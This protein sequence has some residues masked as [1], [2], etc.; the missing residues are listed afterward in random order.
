MRS[1]LGFG[2]VLSAIS[3]ACYAQ[4][5][6]QHIDSLGFLSIG[7]D[8]GAAASA[9]GSNLLSKVSPGNTDY[10]VLKFADTQH[11]TAQDASEQYPNARLT[12]SGALEAVATKDL[13]HATPDSERVSKARFSALFDAFKFMNFY[14]DSSIS[15][16]NDVALDS[17][18]VTIGNL[19]FTPVYFTAGRY[20]VPFASFAGDTISAVGPVPVMLASVHADALSLGYNPNKPNSVVANTFVYNPNVDVNKSSAPGYGVNLALKHKFAELQTKLG[21]GYVSNIADSGGIKKLYS[22]S[23]ISHAVPAGDIN[24]SVSYGNYGVVAEYISALSDFASKDMTYNNRAALPSVLH[25][26]VYYNGRVL[27]KINTVSVG[28]TQTFQALA[29]SLP[30]QRVYI[31]DT[32]NIYK[33]LNVGVELNFDTN[34]AKSNSAVFKTT[35]VAQDGQDHIG[36]FVQI[37]YYF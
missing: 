18:F 34:Y 5:D 22:G 27:R 13:N 3:C 33:N 31:S 17:G 10:A 1:K 7:P 21:G 11:A 30:Q 15:V 29:V 19:Q 20:N 23:K 14:A 28:L 6:V 16:N 25:T 9:D 32:A 35:T 2:I 37:G 4:S 8:N 24:M 36:G 12:M 26:E